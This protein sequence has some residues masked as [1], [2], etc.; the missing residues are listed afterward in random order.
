M[1][2]SNA[3][4]TGVKIFSSI[5]KMKGRMDAW[6]VLTGLYSILM[7]EEGPYIHK[8]AQED[9]AFRLLFI[10]ISVLSFTHNVKITF[11]LMLTFF[12][13]KYSLMSFKRAPIAAGDPS[14][15]STQPL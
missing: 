4:Y 11:G 3:V 14:L 6:L 7:I 5:H 9:F 1:Y 15:D 8:L 10:F 13:L 12:V 2:K